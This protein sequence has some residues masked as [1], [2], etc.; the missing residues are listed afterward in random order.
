MQLRHLGD[1]DQLKQ[2]ES[3][4]ADPASVER[5]LRQRLLEALDTSVVR[6]TLP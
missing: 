6:A 4:L 2:L 3:D 1:S 5:Q